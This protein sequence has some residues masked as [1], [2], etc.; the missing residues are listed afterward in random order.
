V[1]WC[2]S[3]VLSGS[4]CSQFCSDCSYSSTLLST[5]SVRA[6]LVSKA[7]SCPDGLVITTFESLRAHR[8]VLLPVKWGESA[9]LY[10]EVE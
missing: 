9:A 4:F 10:L 3:Q 1:G 5:L 7:T 8:A 6:Q 2:S